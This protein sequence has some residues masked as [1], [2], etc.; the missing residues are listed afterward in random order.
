MTGVPTTA[1]WKK[2]TPP[3]LARLAH[4]PV[5]LAH[6]PV[7]P[8]HRPVSLLVHLSRSRSL[9]SRDHQSQEDAGDPTGM[10]TEA[11]SAT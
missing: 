2:K 6:H 8:A 10:I 7:S 5:S 3:S 4:H 9:Q 11:E 1:N